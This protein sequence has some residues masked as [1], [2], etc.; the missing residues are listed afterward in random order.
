[1]LL[2]WLVCNPWLADDADKSCLRGIL[3]EAAASL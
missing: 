3:V 2:R 1:M